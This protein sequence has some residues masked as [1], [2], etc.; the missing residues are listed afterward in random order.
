MASLTELANNH[1]LL[2]FHV[3]VK[4]K[5]VR[6]GKMSRRAAEG[7]R[8]HV[9]RII[10]SRFNGNLLEQ[11]TQE[12][13][14]GINPRL[15]GQLMRSGLLMAESSVTLGEWTQ[16]YI[17]SRKDVKIRTQARLKYARKMLLDYFDEH[18]PL[19][20]ITSGE[21]DEYRRFLAI[22][23][24]DNTVRRQCSRAKQF[25]RAAMR[26]KLIGDSPFGDMKQLV[27]RANRQR[28]HFVTREDAVKVIDAAPD[29][30]W[31]LLFALA[32]FGGL[33]VP[34]EASVLTW[35][36]VN[37]GERKITIRS[38]KTEK[39]ASGIRI[40]PI[41]PEIAPHLD[42]L[43]EVPPDPNASEALNSLVLGSIV[44]EGKNL[45]KPMEKIILHAG[46]K[47]W[48]KM[49]M[50]CRSTRATELR[51]KFPEHVVVEWL[52][53]T[54]AVAREHYFRVTD[55][56]FAAALGEPKKEQVEK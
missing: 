10:S 30:R 24:A 13:V 19:G 4:R 36:D 32:R 41:F 27:V 22:K 23:Y 37:W 55:D 49:W 11:P 1:W 7:V 35:A 26:R 44:A 34:S 25:F 12:W 51:E 28:D 8:D 6:I 52:G 15:K 21:A 46:L 38:S 31:K 14:R 56:H 39:H 48:K 2:Q 47:P 5:S 17:D 43:F 16:A 33:R 3:G 42:A 53:H 40:I 18:R 20:S 54:A 45:C 29:A 9:E 50:N